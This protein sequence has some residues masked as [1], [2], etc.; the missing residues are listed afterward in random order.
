MRH[1]CVGHP[2]AIFSV[3]TA[4]LLINAE[5]ICNE[6]PPENR[7]IDGIPAYA[8]CSTSTKS[9]IYSNN[10]ID[11][12]TA[13]GGSGWVRTQYGGGYQCTEFAHR[14]LHF[15]WNIT[16]VPNGNAGTWGDKT[17]PAGLVKSTTPVHGDI[18]V[19]APG[20]CGA[21]S[22]TGHVAVVDLVSG[23]SLTIVEQN[24][25]SRRKCKASCAKCFLHAEANNGIVYVRDAAPPDSK[26]P[27][28]SLYSARKTISIR[29]TG[30]FASGAAVRV[31]DLFGRQVADLTGGISAGRAWFTTAAGSP[32]TFVVRVDKN[33]RSACKKITV[34][35]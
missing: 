34:M 22:T 3:L 33:H 20:S 28:F 7:A 27:G 16:S 18:I 6:T 23:T 31:Y 26:N 13:S 10:G 5:N 19:F 1:S 12:R 14:Y 11:T 15:R 21:S 32:A 9:S 30:D 29:L 2:A 24:G 35:E 8:Q 4:A 17:L 25:A